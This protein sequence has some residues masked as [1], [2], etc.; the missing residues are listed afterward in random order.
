[1]EKAIKKFQAKKKL[2]ME[3]KKKEMFDPLLMD[4]EEQDLI[5]SSPSEG[6]L[7]ADYEVIQ[8]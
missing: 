7:M 4:L 5:L 8:E 3:K 2:Q 6:C 1:M